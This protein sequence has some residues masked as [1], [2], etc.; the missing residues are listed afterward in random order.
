[1]RCTNGHENADGVR[2]CGTCGASVSSGGSAPAPQGATA[3]VSGG[4]NFQSL[5]GDLLQQLS[6]HRHSGYPTTLQS[7][8]AMV[9]GALFAFAILVFSLDAIGN[10]DSDNPYTAGVIWTILGCIAAYAVV[11]FVSEDLVVGATTAFIPLS[12]ITSFLLFGSQLEEGKTGMA[13]IVAGL[14]SLAAWFFPIL[15][16]RPALLATSLFTTGL[17]LLVVMVQ[18]SIVDSVEC[19]FYDECSVF[20]DPTAVLTA[21]SEKSATL[22]LILGIVLLAVAWVLD[23][24]DWPQLGRTFIGVGI[25]FEIIGAFGVYESSSD[26]T[27]GSILLVLAGALLVAVAVRQSRKSSLIIGGL[28]A[29]I[30]IAA[31]LVTITEDNEDVTLFAILMIAVAVG[32]GYVALKKSQKITASILQRS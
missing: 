23:R 21:T 3:S 30:G 32:I 5:K 1:M 16:G 4:P 22:M 31:F 29:A 17:G 6:R 25:V 11:K 14:F 15:R 7:T 28:G 20:D 2:F 26:K 12:I 8:M 24:R 27:A 19:G 10:S 18:S 9:S 13:L